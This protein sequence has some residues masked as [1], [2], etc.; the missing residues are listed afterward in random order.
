MTTKSQL[1]EYDR[2]NP[3]L[4]FAQLEHY[5]TTHNIKS[6][7]IRYRDLCSVLPPSVTKKSRDLILNP[8]TPQPYTILRREIMNRFLLSDGQGCSEEKH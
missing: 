2:S 1:P 8:S 7:R 6:E 3:E 4:W 5:F